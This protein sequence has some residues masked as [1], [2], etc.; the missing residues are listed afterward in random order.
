MIPPCL[1]WTTSFAFKRDLVTM[2]E[3]TLIT[4]QQIVV[5]AKMSFVC[6]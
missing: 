4:L 1:A 6:T 2:G 3:Q 5:I